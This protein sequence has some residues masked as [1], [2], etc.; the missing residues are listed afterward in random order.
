L[1][2]GERKKGGGLQD[3]VEEHGGLFAAVWLFSRFLRIVLEVSFAWHFLFVSTSHSMAK[4]T[5]RFLRDVK[6]KISLFEH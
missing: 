4:R 6:A 1:R 2:S 5:A 3:V